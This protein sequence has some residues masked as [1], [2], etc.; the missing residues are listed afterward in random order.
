M[1]EAKDETIHVGNSVY[2][3]VGAFLIVLTG[4]EITVAYIH[5][6]RPVLVPVLLILAAAKFALIAMFFMHLKYEK[7]V[8]NTMFLFPLTIA[9]VAFFALLGLFTYLLHHTAF[10][11]P[12]HIFA[13]LSK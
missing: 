7:W 10:G 1:S 8:L 11:P 4:M 5:A 2:L 6:M 13:G 12:F 3:I 9:G